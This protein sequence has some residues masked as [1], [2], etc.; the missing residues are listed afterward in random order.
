[1]SVFIIT[2]EKYDE[3][4]REARNPKTSLAQRK[5]TMKQ[6]I[7]LK[8]RLENHITYTEYLLRWEFLMMESLAIL[9]KET[10]P[11]VKKC[12]AE[13][14]HSRRKHKLFQRLTEKHKE[15]YNLTERYS[16]NLKPLSQ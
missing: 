13:R 5:I 2:P 11:G 8:L 14:E 10:N 12:L 1:M 15:K 16:D 7:I 6:A 9:G 3:L 4:I